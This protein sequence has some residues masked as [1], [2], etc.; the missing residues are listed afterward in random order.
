MDCPNWNELLA[1]YRNSVSIFKDAVQKI[2]GAQEGSG[3]AVE[4]AERLKLKCRAAS[5]GL[6]EHLRREQHGLG[7]TKSAS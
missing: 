3:L 1:A 4:Q 6:M 2:P 5:D 7:G